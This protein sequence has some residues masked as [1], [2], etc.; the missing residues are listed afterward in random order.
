MQFSNGS[1][2]CDW[3]KINEIWREGGVYDW[4]QGTRKLNG[5]TKQEWRNLKMAGGNFGVKIQ[6]R[7]LSFSRWHSV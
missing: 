2:D 3:L 5:Y 4:P 7:F 1:R 6:K